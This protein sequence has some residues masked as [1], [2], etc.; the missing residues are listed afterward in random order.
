MKKIN[1]KKINNSLLVG[2]TC[3]LAG[4]AF[5]GG[6]EKATT[7]SG[8]YSGV[9][10]AAVSQVA[11][12]E[13]LYFNPAGLASSSSGEVSLNFSPNW[14][15]YEG[16]LKIGSGGA[17]RQVKSLRKLSP[18]FGALASYEVAKGWGVGA[19][20]FVSGGSAADFGKLNFS[21]VNAAYSVL[22]PELKTKLSMTELSIGVGY[23]I[24]DQWSIG[25]SW[26]YSLVSASLCQPGTAGSGTVLVESCLNDLSDQNARGFRIGTQYMEESWGVGLNVRTPV[27]FRA[28]GTA[29][30]TTHNHSATT[31]AKGAADGK[32][33]VI[34]SEFPLQIE[35]GTHLDIAEANR[36]AVVY[37]F[38][39][40]SVNKTLK[41]FIS[42]TAVSPVTTLNWRDQHHFRLG[43]ETKSLGAMPLRVGYVLVTGVT[44]KDFA[45]PTYSSPGLAH[46]FNL[47]SAYAFNSDLEINFSGEYSFASG[48][49][50]V[51]A[52]SA[53]PTSDAS[54][55]IPGKFKSNAYTF[56]TGVTYKF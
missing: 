45:S 35:V 4:S 39:K 29:G 48:S 49:G 27:K 22:R 8:K 41:Q 53:T 11:G 38:T 15:Q 21:S 43:Y 24:T 33:A 6:F 34:E 37:G 44:N 55:A 3:V 18:V 52:R 13:A 12:A 19:G 47:G 36:L 20:A 9:G 26:R 32:A 5:A 31:T 40:Y 2:A 42:G 56:H 17:I 16:P 10:S 25:A 30:I 46:I 23:K 7:W 50:Q 51:A 28:S 1:M 14:G 54:P